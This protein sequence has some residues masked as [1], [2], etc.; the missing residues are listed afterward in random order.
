MNFLDRNTLPLYQERL[1]LAASELNDMEEIICE[2]IN[3]LAGRNYIVTNMIMD[4][5]ERAKYATEPNYLILDTFAALQAKMNS[6]LEDFGTL[7]ARCDEAIEHIDSTYEDLER[8]LN[9]LDDAAARKEDLNALWYRTGE[10]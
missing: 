8:R 7:K 2:A 3:E 6:L 10:E 4:P 9:A 5:E 1:D